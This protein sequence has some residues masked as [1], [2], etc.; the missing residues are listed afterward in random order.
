[1]RSV[2][3]IPAGVPALGVLIGAFVY[4]SRP[5]SSASAQPARAMIR[6]NDGAL[7]HFPRIVLVVRQLM[8][9][10]RG[11]PLAGTAAQ[12]VHDRT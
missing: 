7:R 3:V 11:R 10:A 8:N 1:M 9:G 6:L 2:W 5:A 4:A 12:S